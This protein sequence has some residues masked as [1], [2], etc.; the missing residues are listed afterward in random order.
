MHVIP[1]DAFDIASATVIDV[2]H[3]SIISNSLKGNSVTS[4]NSIGE[5][6]WKRRKTEFLRRV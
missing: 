5:E 1:E 6:A 2:N 3:V 4:W